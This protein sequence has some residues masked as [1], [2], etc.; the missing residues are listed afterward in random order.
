MWGQIDELVAVLEYPYLATKAF[1]CRTF[2]YTDLYLW[3]RRI[4]L[5]LDEIIASHPIFEFA[6]VLKAK[7]KEREKNLFQT[8]VFM[9]AMYLD[10]RFK[11]QLSDAETEVA[12]A[13]LHELNKQMKWKPLAS[14]VPG[15][16]SIDRQIE[17]EMFEN[18]QAQQNDAQIRTELTLAMITYNSVRGTD[19][20]KN[21]L[22][23]WKENK[24][25]HPQL[26]E[27]AKVIFSTA[28][29]ISE[30][31]RNF[32]GFAYI[33]NV[34]H[35]SLLPKNVTNILMVRLNKDLFYQ[36]KQEKIDKILKKS[37]I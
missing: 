16:S 29:S 18:V 32:S 26:Y 23:F 13:T 28:S 19:I 1:E 6:S 21:A 37:E 7:L 36:V 35:Q 2:C 20:N 34:L 12:I 31:E 3:S 9:A 22:A 30:T 15:L 10:P 27:L 24:H 11:M 25:N 33:Y 4:S 17:S 5:R 8:P 14:P